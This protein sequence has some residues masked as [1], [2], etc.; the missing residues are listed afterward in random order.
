MLDTIF[1]LL[2]F[3]LF[4]F[5]ARYAFKRWGW[6]IIV[7]QMNTEELLH[8]AACKKLVDLKKQQQA[9]EQSAL[10]QQRLYGDLSVKID[11]WRSSVN[12]QGEQE[13][14]ARMRAIELMHARY[15]Q[16]VAFQQQ[17]QLEA[18]VMPLALE[19]ARKD[20]QTYFVDEGHQRVY[21]AQIMSQMKR[22]S[23]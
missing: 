9:I 19:A 16:L 2:N 15:Q 14:K 6:P 21:M 11:T 12:R 3:A 5:L 18:A 8:S 17:A 7:R 13:L 4:I 20:L 22:G 1:H 23:S 10:E